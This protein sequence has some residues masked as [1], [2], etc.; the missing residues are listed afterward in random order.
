MKI[1]AVL[2]RLHA[3]EDR[4]AQALLRL[5]ERH[6]TD[7]E[8]HHVSSDLAEWS[9]RHQTEIAATG[10]RF[11]LDLAAGPAARLDGWDG[12]PDP[13]MR[14]L[15]DLSRVHLGATEVSLGWEMVAQ[16]AQ[17]AKDERLLAT[18]QRCHPDTLR[19]MR[20]TNGQIKQL[21]PQ[22]LLS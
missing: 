1:G 10:F 2:T 14:L 13:G 17:A 8:I 9:R 22:T 5:S 21:C 4:L 16:A 12:D 18:A 15:E 20:W 7:H 3:Q 6:E 19:Q 11:G